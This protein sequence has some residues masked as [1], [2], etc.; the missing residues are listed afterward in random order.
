MKWYNIEIAEHNIVQ[1]LH[2]AALDSTTINF[3]TMNSV[4]SKSAP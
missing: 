2:N 3:A 1:H 4:T